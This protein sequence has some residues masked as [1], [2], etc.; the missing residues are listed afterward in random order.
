MRD[1]LERLIRAED[2]ERPDVRVE[3]IAELEGG[4]ETAIYSFDAG[5]PLVARFYAGE[6]GAA[7]AVREAAVLG[8]TAAAGVPVPTVVLVATEPSPFGTAVLVMERVEGVSLAGAPAGSESLISRMA[9]HL[10]ALHRVPID[11][12]FGSG[13]RRFDE[14]GFVKAD[15]GTITAAI[16]D[17]GLSEFDP[18]IGWLGGAMPPPQHESVLHG[19]YHPENIIVGEGG[20]GLTILDWS[21]AD[22]GDY[23]LDLAWS[24]LWTGTMAGER[25]RDTFLKDYGEAAGGP[26]DDLEYFEVL[27]LGA[28][29]VTV[30]S[31]LGGSVEPPVEKITPAAIRS[32]YRETIM[33]V[34]ERFR[35]LTSIRLS[36]I[37]RL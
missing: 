2:P 8:A 9:E 12:V 34:Y 23:R 27:K 1:Y 15:V 25:A 32:G 30:A 16:G 24:A 11:D 29:L 26:I 37:E 28:R 35:E 3:Q 14:P 31:W 7:R 33:T 6:R 4:W 17:Y 10:A 19:D 5:D 18:L 20:S 22:V 13:V 21:F 36:L